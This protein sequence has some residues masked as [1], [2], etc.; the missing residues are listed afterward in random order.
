MRHLFTRLPWWPIGFIRP[1]LANLSNVAHVR[2]VHHFFHRLSPKVLV[3]TFSHSYSLHK[4]SHHFSYS[5]FCLIS[6][7][8]LRHPHVSQS[9]AHTVSTD[10][11][12]DHYQDVVIYAL[13]LC[14]FS[15][16]SP[17]W[18]RSLVT[19]ASSTHHRL[20]AVRCTAAPEP[21]HRSN[22]MWPDYRH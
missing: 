11:D 13:V 14:P 1:L 18:Q 20:L 4:L 5:C 3:T 22:A 15:T 6:F 16:I 9:P 8:L 17:K 10:G 19:A 12:E 21:K 2:L 7:F